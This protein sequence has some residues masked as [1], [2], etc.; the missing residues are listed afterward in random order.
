MQDASEASW[1]APEDLQP[2]ILAAVSNLTPLEYSEPIEGRFGYHLIQLM[3]RKEGRILPLEEVGTNIDNFVRDQK[4]GI[5]L[6]KYTVDLMKNANIEIYSEEF[7]D[8]PS[9]WAEG[10]EGA[11]ASTPR[12]G[13]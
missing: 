6:E 2:E 5:E 8:L 12:R 1:I 9:A 3:D 11:A 7:T 13:R 10:N 4:M